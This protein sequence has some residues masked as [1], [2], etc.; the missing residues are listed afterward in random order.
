MP[1]EPLSSV[2]SHLDDSLSHQSKGSIG[3]N[4]A[5]DFGGQLVDNDQ[6]GYSEA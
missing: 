1:V 5:M 4:D 3:D 6:M 2:H